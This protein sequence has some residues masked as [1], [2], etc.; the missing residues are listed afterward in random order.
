MHI[1]LQLKT[2]TECGRNDLV[3][4]ENAGEVVCRNCG[5]VVESSVINSGPEWR[6]CLLMKIGIQRNEQVLKS[7]S[8]NMTKGFHQKFALGKIPLGTN[9]AYKIE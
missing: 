9:F 8:Q 3:R 5:L 6:G 2:C 7:R 4:D 1:D